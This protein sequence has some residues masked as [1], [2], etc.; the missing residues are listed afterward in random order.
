MT[1]GASVVRRL[2]ADDAEE[3]AQLATLCELA[4]TGEPDPEIVDWIHAGSTRDQFHA[5]GLDDDAGLA[6]FSYADCEPGAEAV[7]IEVRVRPGLDLALGLPLLEAAREAAKACAPA[8]PARVFANSGAMAQRRWLEAQGATEVRRFWRMA[9]NF[10]DT[11]PELPEPPA[12][13]G[14]RL[15]RD[16][17]NDLRTIFSITDTSFAEHFGHTDER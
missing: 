11:R 2:T 1:T 7:E 16:D 15:A 14:V 12:G 13:V 3:I 17:E 5:F 6:A 8:K 9:I 4:E 10:D